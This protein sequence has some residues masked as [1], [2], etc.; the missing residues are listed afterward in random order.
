[1]HKCERP[2][3][4]KR[5]LDNF[6]LRRAH[7]RL[8][9]A[10]FALILAAAVVAT[11]VGLAVSAEPAPPP[12]DELILTGK[13]DYLVHCAPCHGTSGTGNG[14]VAEFL[15]QRPADLTRLSEKSGGRFPEK[16]VFKVIEGTAIVKAHGTREMPV[17]GNV[18]STQALDPFNR[19]QTEREVHDR[20]DRLIGYL[21][22]I[23]RK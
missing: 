14:P 9:S 16:H 10:G 17:W 1:M 20:I 12:S 23:Q 18:F 19:A 6:G 11:H 2:R 3:I 15:K 13:A 4:A 22:S 7:R 8:A 21:K 5:A